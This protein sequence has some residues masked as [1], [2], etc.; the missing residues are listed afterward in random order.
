VGRIFII[1]AV[2]LGSASIGYA[3]DALTRN[4]QRT[5]NFAFATRLGSGIYDVDGRTVQIYRIPIAFTLM[6]ENERGVGVK[7]MLP[8]TFGFVDFKPTDVLGGELPESLDTTSF[9]PGVEVRVRVRANWHLVPFAEAGRAVERTGV[10][11]AWIFTGGLR[12]LVEW[13]PGNFDIQLG[14]ELAVTYANPSGN[15]AHDYF[16]DFETAVE[17]RHGLG[18]APQG[19]ELDLGAYLVADLYLNDTL[20]PLHAEKED[21]GHSFE[22]GLTFGTRK[23]AKLWKIPIPRIGIGYRFGPEISVFRIVLGIA[24]P[25]LER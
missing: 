20:F 3:D 21:S 17:A 16:S 1:I 9:M 5:I 15:A 6:Q 7:L 10:A 13:Q 14:N 2:L 23:P 12:S 4:E 11:S 22:T 18:V 25:S 24:A 19:H 8:L